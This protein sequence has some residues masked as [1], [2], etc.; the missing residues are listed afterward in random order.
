MPATRA[1]TARI[2]LA[3]R[4]H[5]RDGRARH[6]HGR[7]PDAQTAARRVHDLAPSVRSEGSELLE[8]LS[9]TARACASRVVLRARG[10]E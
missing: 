2:A 4:L 7:G 8:A 9:R 1:S 10:R 5:G 3:F 6:R